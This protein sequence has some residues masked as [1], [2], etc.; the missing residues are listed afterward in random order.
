MHNNCAFYYLL[1]QIDRQL[2]APPETEW[3]HGRLDRYSTEQRLRANG[4]L[5]SYL[6]KVFVT[7]N[8]IDLIK[9]LFLFSSRE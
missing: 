5:G 9:I 6:G 4:K 2:I 1:P 3:Y 7:E 8:L